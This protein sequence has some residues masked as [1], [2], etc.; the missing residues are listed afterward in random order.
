MTVQSAAGLAAPFLAKP[1]L[2]G[3]QTAQGRHVVYEGGF[4]AGSAL[5]LSRH[6]NTLAPPFCRIS[7][8]RAT[9]ETESHM[10]RPIERTNAALG[11]L[12]Q[13]GKNG[14]RTSMHPMP[15]CGIVFPSRL[16]MSWRWQRGALSPCANTDA[17]HRTTVGQST[18]IIA[19]ASSCSPDPRH[20]V[21][22]RGTC[23]GASWPSWPQRSWGVCQ[24]RMT[25]GL[26]RQRCG[27]R[28]EERALGDD[29]D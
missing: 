27:Y 13:S 6:I 28:L 1:V 12:W 2:N 22:W 7:A 17:P 25:T 15:S 20:A 3:H 26:T 14:P 4:L 11:C 18:G 10:E 24:R 8:R 23:T 5:F 9:T 29:I 16:S 19:V 21:A